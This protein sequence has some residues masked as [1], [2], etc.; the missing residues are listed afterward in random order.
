MPPKASKAHSSPRLETI[1]SR[2]SSAAKAIRKSPVSPRKNGSRLRRALK[3]LPTVT[4]FKE[5]VRMIDQ[6]L[7][8]DTYK[9]LDLT[10]VEEV[11]EAIRSLR[12]RG[13]PAIG[14]AAAYGL[15]LGLKDVATQ[16]SAEVFLQAPSKKFRLFGGLTSHSGKSDV[17]A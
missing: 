17:G 13:A 9:I 16:N 4:W 8:P 1:A 15:C 3:P 5:H 11:W 7:L 6:T 12:V 10:R 14:V 2:R